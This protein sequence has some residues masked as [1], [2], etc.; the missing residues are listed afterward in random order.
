MRAAAYLRLRE[1][2]KG[3]FLVS[4][5]YPRGAGGASRR[6]VV[7]EKV[8]GAAS[9]E[10][11]AGALRRGARCRPPPAPPVHA[12]A[13]GAN[14]NDKDDVDIYRNTPVRLDRR[15]RR[16]PTSAPPRRR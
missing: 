3:I 7:A 1:Y 8:M 15:A 10:F 14:A 11:S 5:K 2:E 6:V 9:A 12:M 4:E 13:L 16:G